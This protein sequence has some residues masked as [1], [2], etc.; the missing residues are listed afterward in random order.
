MAS[1]YTH[2]ARN[3]RKTWLIF[4]LFLGVVI[5]IGFLFAQVYQSS[6]ILYFAI[7]FSLVMNIIAYWYSDK[8]VLR[9]ANAKPVTRENAR[10]L[11]NIVENLAITAG[12]PTPKIYIVEDP[13]PNAFATGRDPKHAVVAVTTG[14]LERL[15]R[16]ELEGVLAHEFSHIGNRD[17]L[18]STVAI[19]LVGFVSLL[20]DI[21]FRSL[22][23][24]GGR[25]NNNDKNGGLFLVIGIVLSALA[26]F[27]ATLMHLAISRRREFLADTSGALLTRYPEALA[28]ALEKISSDQ[29]QLK[30]ANNTTA[31]LWLSDP[32]KGKSKK[33]FLHSLFMTHPP[34]AE[35]INI[36]RNMKT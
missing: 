29:H 26:P 16:S 3:I 19:I 35:R 15:D 8:I 25:R 33:F 31:H 23:W 4:I 14:L 32:F 17:M 34:V 1:L 13:A 28:S 36:L 24:G 21:F 6:A 18:V 2:K 11:Y 5:G 10:E 9:M 30:T 27:V 12:L 22:F 20:A 7:G